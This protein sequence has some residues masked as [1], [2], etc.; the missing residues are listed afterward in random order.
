MTKARMA[1][2]A[3]L[4]LFQYR[5]NRQMIARLGRKEKEA[6]PVALKKQARQ[7]KREHNSASQLT[8]DYNNV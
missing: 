3:C 1:W 6:A 4:R 8:Q 5:Y 7:A 2:E